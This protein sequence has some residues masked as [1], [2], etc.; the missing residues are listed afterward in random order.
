MRTFLVAGL[1]ALLIGGPALSQGSG[2]LSPG[3]QAPGQQSTGQQT[4][5]PP[6]P[7]A[8]KPE[9]LPGKPAAVGTP[10]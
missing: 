5:R 2:Q 1:S 3:Q 4:V 9:S 6:Q 8:G 7:T 10:A